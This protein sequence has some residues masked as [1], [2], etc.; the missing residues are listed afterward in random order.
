[1]EKEL[2]N[3]LRKCLAKPD[4]EVDQAS[5]QQTLLLAKREAQ[6]KA[7][8]RRAGFGSFLI[9]Y[10]KHSGI[11]IWFAQAVI[12][13]CMG[14]LLVRTFH[15]YLFTQRHISML[16]CGLA[17]FIFM[18]AMPVFYRS[19]RYQMQEIEAV[20][21]M[22][23]LR[24]FLAEMI[25]IAV[26]DAVM[27]GTVTGI[28]VMKASYGIS[29]SL[30]Y[31]FVPFLTMWCVAFRLLRHVKIEKI[32]I[33]CSVMCFFVLLLIVLLDAFYPACYDGR[34]SAGWA[35]ICAGLLFFCI[36]QWKE[37]IKHSKEVVLWN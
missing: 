33:Y 9:W 12:L 25:T 16:L 3:R 4:Q 13:A 23:Y 30:F 5:Y 35:E 29:H 14:I 10:M 27:I 32:P 21:R 7:E 8:R 17:V 22:S 2:E 26:G 28:T 34:F 19:S 37:I 18:T 1:M 15:F 31:L 36:Y 20:T 24:I 11:R 6:R